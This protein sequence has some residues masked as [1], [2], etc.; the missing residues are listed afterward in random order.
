ME[1]GSRRPGVDDDD[2]VDTGIPAT[3]EVVIEA[4]GWRRLTPR[5]VAIARR[6]VAE[7][8]AEAGEAGRVIV[9]L[10]DDRVM[11]RLN[12]THR[13]KDKPTNVLSFPAYAAGHLG[14]I[15]LGLGVVGREAREAGKRPAAHLA[16]LVAHGTLH[17][18]GHDHV[19]AGEAMRMERAEA[20][21]LH[22][23]RLPNPWSP[24]R[25][26]AAA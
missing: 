1:P 5:A 19:A 8:L 15:A 13:G 18:L 24:H 9:L 11:R 16:H 10:T 26:G 12:Y 25:R 23:L 3:I 22:R 7:A 6:A 2:V 4:P 14:D 21:I 20:R 17:L